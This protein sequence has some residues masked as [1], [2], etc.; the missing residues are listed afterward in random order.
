MGRAG[1][2]VGIKGRRPDRT[3]NRRGKG[4]V[5]LRGR[6][7][8]TGLLTEAGTARREELKGGMY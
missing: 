4:G 5:T 2:S 1:E 3:L 7:A 6:S 8:P